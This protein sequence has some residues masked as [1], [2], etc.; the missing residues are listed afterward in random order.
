MSVNLVMDYKEFIRFRG[1]VNYYTEEEM[2]RAIE[3]PAIVHAINTF[4]VK[5]RFWE[6][7]SDS[8]WADTYQQ[9]REKS[10]WSGLPQMET[11]YTLKQRAMKEVW[12]LVPRKASLFAARLVRNYI[13]PRMARNRDD[14]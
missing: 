4:Y 7:G 11:K 6:K 9:Y 13:R 2:R 1:A 5:K 8:P 12:H 3:H 10:P 14:E